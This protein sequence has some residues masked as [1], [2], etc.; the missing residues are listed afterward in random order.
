MRGEIEKDA[1]GWKVFFSSLEVF[2]GMG[3]FQVRR[4]ASQKVV[5]LRSLHRALF[6]FH[7]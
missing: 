3:S 7:Y 5:F 1:S 6:S 4:M 2:G